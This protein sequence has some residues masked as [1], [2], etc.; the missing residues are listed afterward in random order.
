M[1][2]QIHTDIAS[3]NNVPGLQSK[4]FIIFYLSLSVDICV[5]LCLS[6][7]LTNR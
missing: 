4:S 5:Y 7:C 2:T 6:L 1:L 3:L